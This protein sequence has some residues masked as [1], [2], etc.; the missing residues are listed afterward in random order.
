MLETVF[1]VIELSLSLPDKSSSVLFTLL[2]D[3]CVWYRWKL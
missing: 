2:Y 3:L 1:E